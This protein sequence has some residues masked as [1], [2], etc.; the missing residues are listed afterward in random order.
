MNGGLEEAP[1][2]DGVA[3]ARRDTEINHVGS[4][5]RNRQEV[6][7]SGSYEYNRDFPHTHTAV[8]I[9]NPL[10]RDP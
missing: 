3:I 10:A 6:G 2:V 9:S 5:S 8:W 1:M 4:N 7:V